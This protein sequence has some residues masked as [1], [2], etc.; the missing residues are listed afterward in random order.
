M[1]EHIHVSYLHFSFAAYEL[2]G[3]GACEVQYSMAAMG[4]FEFMP[5]VEKEGSPVYRQ[6]QSK[7]IATNWGDILLYRWE[8]PLILSY[9]PHTRSGDEWLVVLEEEDNMTL[10]KAKVGE[11]PLIPRSGVGRIR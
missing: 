6:A 10:L 8:S 1:S 11:D 2:T 9:P 3:T 7:E 4:R 5:G